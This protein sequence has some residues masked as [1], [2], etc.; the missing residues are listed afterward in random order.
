MQ[1]VLTILS[2]L[3][4]LTSCKT[5]SEE[6]LKQ[7][8][9]QIQDYIKKNSW[10][11]E[12]TESGL[13]YEIIEEGNGD[14]FIRFNDQVTFYY[15]GKLTD[16]EIFQKIDEDVPLTFRARELIIGWQ[17]GLSFI[18]EGGTIR[19]IIP[20]HLGYGDKQTGLVPPN[21]ILIYEL[22]VLEVI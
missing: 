12:R 11:M 21:S 20:P 14:E 16:G 9:S 13:Y 6:D 8:D 17:E 18:K 7:F 10:N 2:M 15:T 22:S 5:Y 3:F 1:K 19:L 4:I